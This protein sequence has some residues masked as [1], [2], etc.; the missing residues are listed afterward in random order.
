MSNLPLCWRERQGLRQNAHGN[1]GDQTT[2][3]HEA[4]DGGGEHHTPEQCAA[5]S[6]ERANDTQ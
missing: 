2:R 4:S 5:S 1:E 3:Q 6:N